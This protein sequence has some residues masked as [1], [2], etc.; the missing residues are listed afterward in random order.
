MV[1]TKNKAFILKRSFSLTGFTLIELLISVGVIVMM[2]AL[3]LPAFSSF[4]KEQDL[5]SAAQL[6]RDAILEANNLALAPRGAEGG[7]QSVASLP[8]QGKVPGA[9]YYRI[10]FYQDGETA[11]YEIHEQTNTGLTDFSAINWQSIK[12]G[13]LPSTVDYCSFDPADLKGSTNQTLGGNGIIYS[14]RQF[15]RV[16]KPSELGTFKIVLKHQSFSG[17]KS[18]E[19]R[20]E[21]GQVNIIDITTPVACT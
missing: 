2:L 17:R 14:I 20:A 19:V 13:Q 16:V 4:Q 18:V 7:E 10:V 5:L 9:D 11:K 12:T 21:T 3:S 8:A 1:N 15:G 6:L